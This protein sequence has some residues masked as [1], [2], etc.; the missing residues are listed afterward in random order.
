M[1]GT[2]RLK[3]VE[4]QRGLRRKKRNLTPFKG[5]LW[6]RIPLKRSALKIARKGKTLLRLGEGIGG[7]ERPT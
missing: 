6:S 5:G 2:P 7:C 4:N 3:K 1:G